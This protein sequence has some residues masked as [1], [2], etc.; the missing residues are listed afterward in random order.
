ML[1]WYSNIPEEVTY[2]VQRFNDYRGVYLGTFF[3]NFLLPFFVLM[4]RD[5]KRNGIFLIPVALIIFI[6]HWLDVLIMVLPGTLFKEGTVGFVEIG[7]FLTFLGV[8]IYVVLNA[9]TKAPLQTKNHPMYDESLHL[10]H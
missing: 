3:I 5:A 9:L 6:G 4:S 7:M 10:H 8:F 1:I 2:Y